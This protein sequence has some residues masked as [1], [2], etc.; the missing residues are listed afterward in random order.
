MGALIKGPRN[1]PICCKQGL[2]QGTG[3]GAPP[4]PGRWQV[5]ESLTP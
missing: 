1:L 5:F 4:P 3:K 2:R